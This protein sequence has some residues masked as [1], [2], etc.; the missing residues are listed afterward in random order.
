MAAE[1]AAASGAAVTVF[2]AMPSCGRKFLVAGKGG[3][4]LTH[5]ERGRALLDRYPAI[6]P[7]LA[8]ALAAFDSQALREWAATLG[9]N[10]FVGS[11]GRVFPSDLKAA[12]LLRRWLTRLRRQGV[13]FALRH[14]WQGWNECGQLCFRTATGERLVGAD[15]TV[16]ALGGASWPR[17]GADGS[18][19]GSVTGR[20]LTV[21]PL[22]ASNAGFECEF[23]A[24]LRARYAGAVA[25]NVVL[26][27]RDTDG[28]TRRSPGDLVI[29][30][31][32]LEGACL[33]ALSA[34]LRTACQRAGMARLDIDLHPG[35]THLALREALARPRGKRS[36]SEHLRRTSGLTGAKAA[37]L[38]E[39]L[40]PSE[41]GDA[42]AVAARIKALPLTL[43]APRPLAEAISTAG[44]VR[45]DTL[46]DHL[47][48]RSLPGLF[49]AGEMLDWDAPTGGYLL[50]ACWATGRHA[51]AAAA[52]WARRFHDHEH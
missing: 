49:F 21:T 28:A 24:H 17:L 30:E 29:T 43:R 1:T 9:I 19:V 22:A 33:Y 41:R 12:P 6:H 42:D 27:C 2:D 35:R 13:D 48:A 44:G 36:F 31:Y 51:G 3:L 37:L 25:K 15:A 5:R 11:S 7:T 39:V 14:R 32:G 52:D 40:P 16:L 10:T 34:H 20:G 23:S 46:D 45:F 18:W 47:M 38:H 50:T 26:S 4:N 8:G